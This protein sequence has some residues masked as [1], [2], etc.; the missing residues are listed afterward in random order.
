MGTCCSYDFDLPYGCE[1]KPIH[2][3]KRCFLCYKKVFYGR[4]VY[5]NLCN[6]DLG[7]V[8]CTKKW[9]LIQECCP[10]CNGLKVN[11]TNTE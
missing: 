5:C 4:I 8:R 10:G 1:M 3:P 9:F 2:E 11:V 6:V 7:H